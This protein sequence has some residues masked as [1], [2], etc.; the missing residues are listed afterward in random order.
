LL[1][2]CAHYPRGRKDWF[3]GAGDSRFER[4]MTA[5]AIPENAI[6]ADCRVLLALNH[7][8]ERRD[9]DDSP[10][11]NRIISSWPPRTHEQS[12]CISGLGWTENPMFSVAQPKKHNF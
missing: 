12:G 8:F 10:T 11:M 5:L 2:S 1:I 6:L 4:K 7:A 9:H 3:N